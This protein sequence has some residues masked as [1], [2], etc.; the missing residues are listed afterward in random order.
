[1]KS[2]A[3]ALAAAHAQT[4]ANIAD[5]MEWFP[6]PAE[7]PLSQKFLLHCEL[8]LPSFPWPSIVISINNLINSCR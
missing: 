5:F 7:A 3:S 4:A 8:S 1:L 6:Y 2:A